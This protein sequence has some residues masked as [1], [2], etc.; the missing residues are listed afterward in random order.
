MVP[1]GTTG[2]TVQMPITCDQKLEEMENPFLQIDSR[3][4]AMANRL[5]I[6]E[7][8]LIDATSKS[9]VV[10]TPKVENPKF[11]S[12]KKAHQLTGLSEATFRKYLDNGILTKHKFGKSVRIDYEELM[13]VFEYKNR[14]K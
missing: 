5:E 7:N 12:V 14:K 9:P 10:T 3:L 2:T 13:K 6:I 8:I 1:C 11:V 4:V